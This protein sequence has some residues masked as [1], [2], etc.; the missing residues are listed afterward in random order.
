VI[1]FRVAAA[2]VLTTCLLLVVVGCAPDKPFTVRVENR[3][4]QPLASLVLVANGSLQT[5]VPTLVAGQSVSTSPRVGTSENT[6]TLLDARGREYMLLG[7]FEGDPG[8]ELTVV[9][10]GIS[11]SGLVGKVIDKTHYPQPQ[12]GGSVPL[13]PLKSQGGP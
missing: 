11:A 12:R 6:L 13:R 5:S 3:S 7:Y 4:Q 8:G 10:D 9:V 1:R 2:A